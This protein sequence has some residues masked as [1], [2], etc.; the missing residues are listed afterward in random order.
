MPRQLQGAEAL[1]DQMTTIAPIN[2][3]G[4]G[5]STAEQA[6]V[7]L[8]GV[9]RDRIGQLGGIAQA[10]TNG[11]IPI[12]ILQEIGL[13]VGYSITGPEQVVIGQTAFFHISNYN[14]LNPVEIS[15]DVGS[16]ELIGDV[17]HVTPPTSGTELTLTVGIR[18]LVL[19]IIEAGMKDPVILF[20]PGD[21]TP[22]APG[23]TFYTNGFIAGPEQYSEWFEITD[24]EYTIAFPVNTTSIICEGRRGETGEA[25]VTIGSNVYGFG[26]SLT[27]RELSR[28]AE[29][30]V[31]ITRSGSG[32][33]RCRWVS[34][35]AIHQSSSWDIATDPEFTNFVHTSHDTI[36]LT[37]MVMPELDTLS[38][39]YLR[40]R[41]NTQELGSTQWSNTVSFTT[42]G[43]PYPTV[44]LAK[45][46]AVDAIA[47]DEFGTTV[48]TD[49]A[50]SQ[51]V[52][53]SY[54]ADPGSSVNAGAIYT[55][56]RTIDA[57]NQTAK[58]VSG[59]MS[60]SVSMTVT[61][62]G[63]ARIQANSP[64]P[65][66][67]TYL[68]SGTVLIPD[69]ATT[70]TITGKGGTGTQ[71]LNPGR[72]AVPGYY[73][74]PGQPYIAPSGYNPGQ[75]Y[76]EPYYSNPGQSYIAPSGYN[77]GQPYIAPTY[78]TSTNLNPH[79][80]QI[81]EG[82]TD[83]MSWPT[84][85][86]TPGST[87]PTDVTVLDWTPDSSYPGPANYISWNCP[88][89]TSTMTSPGQPYIEPYYSNPGQSYIAP[90]GYNPGQ[91]YIAP[92]YSYSGQSYI[93]PSGWVAEVPA[94]APY[95]ESAYGSTTS[96]TVNG[97]SYTY[98]GGF[99]SG[100]TA[101][102]QTNTTILNAGSN[103][104]KSVAISGDGLYLAS[105][106]PSAKVGANTLQGLVG[107]SFK[108]ADVWQAPLQLIASDGAANDGFGV[109]VDLDSD[110]NTAII[111][112]S[113]DD[114]NK[115]AVYVFTRSGVIWTQQA[116]I[117]PADGVANDYFGYA[118]S[119]SSDGNTALIGAY[120]DDDKGTDSGSVY[121]FTRSGSVWTQ[122]AKLTS[123]DGAAGDY[124]GY[125]INLSR[126]GNTAAVGA[127]KDDTA[128]GGVYI[129]RRVGVTWTQQAKLLASDGVTSD[130][131]GY[132]VALSETGDVLIASATKANV[133]K[134]AVYVFTFSEGV[135]IQKMK[136]VASDATANASFGNSLSLNASGRIAYITAKGDASN[137]GAV[138]VFQ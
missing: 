6:I 106:A 118:V 10:D 67:Q 105:G 63:S 68:V 110:G 84:C 115:G 3:G 55:Y 37:S 45:F 64:T 87:G 99:G 26:V 116:K 135:W 42:A 11:H 17:I 29:A 124:F 35:L 123:T 111:G 1:M 24:T 36:N 76:I 7:N 25:T 100:N 18:S 91:P 48:D 66:D 86:T 8:G 79:G 98:T 46:S 33:V 38:T 31:T 72:A 28:N 4:T 61:S 101:V 23:A 2:K 114:T 34:P 119:L 127:Y 32:Y 112:A 9:S 85:R 134:G 30:S 88:V 65:F 49:D 60:T 51:F 19:P 133:N 58:L 59:S 14:M 56:K 90:S 107:I 44:E 104:G 47:G 82:D 113:G 20:P 94:I 137:R 16:C 75:P 138:Y 5:A 109:S 128:K 131:L 13:S 70:V 102:T 121:V 21:A 50:A 136:L 80:R 54:Q 39:F 103:F 95:Y 126:D 132:A 27:Q 74:N 41:Y 92:Y 52:A 81:V 40:V 53:G 125:A 43:D 78:S 97:Q 69:G 57:F 93:A 15:T 120:A 83:Y 73:S 130:Q 62:D 117:Q 71:T 12:S 77:P 108:M 96:V 129:F 122:Q 89:T 22:I